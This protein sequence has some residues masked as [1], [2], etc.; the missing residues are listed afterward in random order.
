[1]IQPHPDLATVQKHFARL[2]AVAFA[3]TARRIKIETSV[4]IT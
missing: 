3:S 1:M 2:D 4:G